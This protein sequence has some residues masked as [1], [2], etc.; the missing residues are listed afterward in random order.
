MFVVGTSDS[1]LMLTMCALQMYYYYYCYCSGGVVADTH[2][3]HFRHVRSL[4][5]S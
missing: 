3:R 5:A 2:R 4:A 1:A